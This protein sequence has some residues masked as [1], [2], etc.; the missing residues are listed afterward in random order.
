MTPVK[1]FVFSVLVLLA[2]ANGG[3][4]EKLHH[5]SIQLISEVR[6]FEPGKPFTVGI[7]MQMDKGWHIYWKNPGDAGIPPKIE[8]VLPKGFT[9]GEMQ[10]PV[11]EK[12]STP[13]LMSFGYEGSALLLV[14][15]LAPQN[16]PAGEK[17]T[18]KAKVEWLECS[19]I[20]LPASD[21]VSIT[22]RAE[23]FKGLNDLSATLTRMGSGMKTIDLARQSLPEKT[24]DWDVSASRDGKALHLKFFRK[25][26]SAVVPDTAFFFPDQAGFIDN[27]GKQILR[28]GGDGFMLDVP[29]A[30][31]ASANPEKISGI[32]TVKRNAN[33]AEDAFL[34]NAP[35]KS[36]SAKIVDEPVAQ[37][38]GG[39]LLYA[40]F[41]GLILN[42]MPCVFPVLSL[43]ILGFVN[44]AGESRSRLALHGVMFSLGVL[45]SFWVLAGALISLRTSGQL[46]GWG[47]Q[48]QNPAFSLFLAILL[49]LI[50]LNLMGVFEIGSSLTG[51]GGRPH[52]EGLRASFFSGVLATV[53]ATP[54]TA[55]FMGAAVAYALTQPAGISFLVF[56]F[57][58]FGMAAPYMALTLSPGLMRFL[59]R[60]GAWMETFKQAMAFPMFGAVIWMIWIL[61]DQAGSS[62]VLFSLGSLLLAGM[63]AWIYGKWSQ[64][65]RRS[66]VR[67]GA[68][69]AAVFFLL[70]ALWP[71]KWIS[72]FEKSPSGKSVEE[73]GW[74]IFTPQRLEELRAEGKPVFIDFTAKWCLTCQVNK[75]IALDQAEVRR[76]FREKGVTLLLADWTNQDETIRTALA[77]YGRAGVPFY[78]LYGTDPK[79]SPVI[80]PEILTPGIVQDALKKLK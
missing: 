20:C 29:I 10:W 47:F 26:P 34:I 41:G 56:T 4:A 58:A 15:I 60:P 77:S 70:L 27:V 68:Q 50:G 37:P 57:L 71:L 44:A 66:W 72:T 8:W 51:L 65:D 16:L 30:Y 14:D 6:S 80:L 11:P 42:L 78:V 49:F 28:P 39:I 17:V 22:L 59:P 46:L 1:Q 3:F 52:Q 18:L 79:A 74:E 64:T 2:V 62:G 13:P 19:D 24:K 63:A 43:K 61:S 5:T 53:V 40:F 32:M 21:E 25:S 45:V 9:A 31:D 54:C 38:L 67:G 48:F 23:S 12:I 35:I 36:A 73:N 76:K 55:P 7:Q 75:A 33:E 69:V